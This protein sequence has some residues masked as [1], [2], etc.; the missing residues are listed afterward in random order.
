MI[1]TVSL[2][3]RKSTAALGTSPYTTIELPRQA[4]SIRLAL[5]VESVTGGPSAMT[6]T[7]TFE[8][9]MPSGGG[10]QFESL[11]N[12]NAGFPAWYALP[13]ASNPHALPDGEFAAF[14]N[15]SLPTGGE[16]QLKTVRGGAPVR[17]KIAWS[18]TGGTSPA[19][20]LTATA[21]I[22]EP[23]PVSTAKPEPGL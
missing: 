8:F 11:V 16:G 22:E 3:N 4:K 14:T 19:A 1:R 21:F 12:A 23:D 13:A 9:L 18:F 2:L 20:L 7:P 6:L 10:G 17:L 5:A 15:V